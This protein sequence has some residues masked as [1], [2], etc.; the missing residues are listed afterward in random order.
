MRS[1]RTHVSSAKRASRDA[2]DQEKHDVLS[3]VERRNVASVRAHTESNAP[4][5]ESRGGGRSDVL[6]GVHSDP[7]YVHDSPS[8]LPFE[9]H[10]HVNSD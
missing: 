4:T 6:R 10:P 9:F 8:T 3:G 5:P 7:P 2:D 1:E